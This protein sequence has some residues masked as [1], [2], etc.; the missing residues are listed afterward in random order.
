[1]TL[2]TNLPS[3]VVLA[4]KEPY[5]GFQVWDSNF[6]PAY[7]KRVRVIPARFPVLDAQRLRS[8]R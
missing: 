8:P 1:M 4:A 5:N 6:L 2:N 7:H 3:F